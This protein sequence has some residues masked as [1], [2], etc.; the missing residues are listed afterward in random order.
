MSSFRRYL[1]L[2]PSYLS[3]YANAFV[4]YSLHLKLKNWTLDPHGVC[5]DTGRSGTDI[6]IP[7]KTPCMAIVSLCSLFRLLTYLYASPDHDTSRTYAK[8]LHIYSIT[9]SPVTSSRLPTYTRNSQFPNPISREAADQI[10]P[11]WSPIRN[12]YQRRSII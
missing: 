6:I 1:N 12:L 8:L 2:T 5:G 9:E 10:P 11:L 3:P 7:F 4:S